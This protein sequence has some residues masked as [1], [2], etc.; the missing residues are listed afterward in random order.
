MSRKKVYNISF[1]LSRKKNKYIVWMLFLFSAQYLA[2]TR[3]PSIQQRDFLYIIFCQIWFRF[4]NCSLYIFC[5]ALQ[6]LL[7]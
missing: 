4:A 2:Q 7:D 6:N 5:F 1:D 3:A